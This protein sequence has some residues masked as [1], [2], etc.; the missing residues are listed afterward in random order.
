MIAPNAAACST[1]ISPARVGSGVARRV[2]FTADRAIRYRS[3][4]TMGLSATKGAGRAH[5]S[6]SRP[7]TCHAGA[8][9]LAAV[10]LDHEVFSAAGTGSAPSR[11]QRPT[12]L[13]VAPP[14]LAPASA[15]Y[16]PQ[17]RDPPLRGTW[18]LSLR[19]WSGLLAGDARKV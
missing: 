17:G 10:W 1:Y 6:Y 11:S 5:G 13:G 14:A 19:A 2:L 7:D 16:H 18:G 4:A 9:E 15:I 8:R 3:T 12:T